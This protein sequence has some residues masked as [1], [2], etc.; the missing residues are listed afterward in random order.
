MSNTTAMPPSAVR[1]AWLFLVL[2]SI[3]CPPVVEG[4]EAVQHLTIRASVAPATTLRV[5]SQVL[6]FDVDSDEASAV[7]RLDY[8]ASARTQRDGEVILLVETTRSVEGP[9]GAAD[10]DASLTM[11]GEGIPVPSDEHVVAERWI[12][13]GTRSGRIVFTLRGAAAG[14]YVLPVRVSL[15]IP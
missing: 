1:P 13:G 14:R 9:G 2:L 10:L 15:S 6:V 3:G 11:G 12:G 4:S 7:A 5:S 8:T